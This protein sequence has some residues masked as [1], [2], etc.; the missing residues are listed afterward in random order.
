MQFFKIKTPMG[1]IFEPKLVIFQFIH[2][3]LLEND[4]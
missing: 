1:G 2:N 4:E 3:H